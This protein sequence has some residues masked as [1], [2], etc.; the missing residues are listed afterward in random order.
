MKSP[1]HD[2][3]ALV[4][5]SSRGIGKAI[6]SHLAKMGCNI[7]INYTKQGGSSEAQAMSLA[8]EINEMGLRSLVIRAD[9]SVREEVK[10]MFEKVK[11]TFNR[12]DLL[13][14][15]AAK[16]PF[17]PIEKLFERELR[18]LVEVNLFG[19]IFCIQQAIPLLK[20]TQGT[21]VFVSSLGSRFYNPSYP[22]GMMKSAMETVVRDLSCSLAKD[23]ISV[24]A[25]CGGIV[26]TDSYKVLRQIWEG[27][28]KIP[29]SLIVDVSEIA[30]VVSFL[31]LPASRG[32]RGQTIVVDRGMSN[33]II[34]FK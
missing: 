3:V 24:N 20:E 8:E 16:T 23:K 14:L 29:E 33:Q 21:I 17:K 9:I 28:D 12:L 11:E 31:C 1:L 5:G 13:I 18:Q 7:V 25:V 27:L 15:N 10:A 6:A 26:K 2:K 32:I 34:H 22:L 30:E 19:N 4:T